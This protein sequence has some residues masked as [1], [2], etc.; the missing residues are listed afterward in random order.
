MTPSAGLLLATLRNVS[1]GLDVVEE[2]LKVVSSGDLADA[3]FPLAGRAAQIHLDAKKH[4]YLHVLEMC[5]A[6]SLKTWLAQDLGRAHDEP[7]LLL[8]LQEVVK[9]LEV[10]EVA[11]KTSTS[12]DLSQATFP[13]VADEARLQLEATAGAYLHAL[14][15]CNSTSVREVL[16]ACGQHAVGMNEEVPTNAT[17]QAGILT[18]ADG[19]AIDLNKIQAAI[20]FGFQETGD[21]EFMEV[22]TSLSS[23]TGVEQG[24]SGEF[25]AAGDDHK[26][27]VPTRFATGDWYHIFGIGGG[28]TR[29]RIVIDLEEEKLVAAQEWTGDK[30]KDIRGVRLNDLSESVI[31]VNQLLSSLGEWAPDPE[32]S[33][34]LPGWAQRD[35]QSNTDQ[36]EM[37]IAP[38][39]AADSAGIRER[40]LV[41][42]G[43][44]E[45]GCFAGDGERAPFVVFDV[46]AQGNIAGPFASRDLAEKHRDEILAG[47]EPRLDAKRLTQQLADIDE[48]RSP[49]SSVKDAGAEV[50]LIRAAVESYRELMSSPTSA[51]RAANG[52]DWADQEI[53]ACDA[54][55]KSPLLMGGS[56]SAGELVELGPLDQGLHLRNQALSLLQAA[57]DADG[58][59][60]FTVTHTHSFGASTY[61]L[62]AAEKPSEEVAQAVLDEKFE[63]E[64]DE[65]ILVEDCFTLQEMTG[66]ANT[67]RLHDLLERDESFDHYERPSF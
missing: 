60:A 54:L 4:A 21:P 42:D 66:V 44:D 25:V 65:T 33:N 22:G 11:L 64:R 1:F 26:A 23:I 12:G 9:G 16:V 41:V 50:T 17:L 59:K 31:E 49:S 24:P 45:A 6:E 3:P 48:G 13:L 43:L 36:P 61:V 55:L 28:E 8:K 2:A 63:P 14:E 67:S 57:Q 46:D 56:P 38:G 35:G 39:G 18:L 27:N 15:M 37:S 62:W 34:Q 20:N 29:C 58:L 32:F 30:F 52:D 47:H 40:H 53:R 51:D 19:R 5:S 10:V 7:T